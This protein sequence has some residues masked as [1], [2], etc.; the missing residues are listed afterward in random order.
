MEQQQ[1]MME[2]ELSHEEVVVKFD[3]CCSRNMS[4]VKGRLKVK[5]QLEQ[6]IR[7]TGFNGSHNHVTEVGQSEDDKLVY[8]ERCRLSAHQYARAGAAILL[9]DSGVVLKM[10]E[11]QKNKLEVLIAECETIKRLVVNNRTYE[12]K[13]TKL[14]EAGR[15]LAMSNTA[16]RYFNSKVHVSNQEERIITYRS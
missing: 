6:D 15:E 8:S 2:K 14:A 9:A 10:T 4:G 11:E 1:K 16:T 3:S 7:I 12:V 13:Q 5:S